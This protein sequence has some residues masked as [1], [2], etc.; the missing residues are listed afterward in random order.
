MEPSDH[1][2][3]TDLSLRMGPEDPGMKRTRDETLSAHER[4]LPVSSTTPRAIVTGI[5]GQGRLVLEPIGAG[6]DWRANWLASGDR[7]PI[8]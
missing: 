6:T 5:L 1:E 3:G 4:A 8:Q 2:D 7:S